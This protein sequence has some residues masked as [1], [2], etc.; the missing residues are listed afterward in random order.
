MATNAII[1]IT[2]NVTQTPGIGRYIAGL[3]RRI[4]VNAEVGIK[5]HMATVQDLANQILYSHVKTRTPR[6]LASYKIRESWEQK[7]EIE[8]NVVIGELKNTSDHAA[9][10]ELGT[11]DVAPIKPKGKFLWIE[12][13]YPVTE[14]AGQPGYHYLEQASLNLE[15]AF[16]DT[17]SKYYRMAME[18]AIS[19]AGRGISEGIGRTEDV[20]EAVISIEKYKQFSAYVR[21]RKLR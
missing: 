14:V 9:A 15:N 13:K 1:Q 18:G 21:G 12:G 2:I 3:K 6:Q 20:G 17:M 7:T 4:P 8:G 10:V 5:K 11:L 16:V 19:M